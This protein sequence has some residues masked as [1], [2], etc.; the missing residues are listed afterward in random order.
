M[1]T[2]PSDFKWI[3]SEEPVGF[4]PSGFFLTFFCISG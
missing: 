4:K 1:A 3:S 2:N